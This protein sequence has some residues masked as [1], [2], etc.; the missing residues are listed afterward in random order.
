MSIITSLDWVAIVSYV[1]VSL[2][3]GWIWYGPLF[4]TAWLEAQGLSKED[5]TPAPAPYIVAVVAGI[6][7]GG[8]MDFLVTSLDA[9]TV[10]EG[11]WIGL[12][13]GFAFIAASSITDGEFAKVSRHSHY[14]NGGYRVVLSVLGGILF[15]VM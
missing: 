15:V 9:T 2:A 14:I 13:V 1:V 4:G 6:L 7:T 12:L 10:V 8:G 3:L 11:V 5:V